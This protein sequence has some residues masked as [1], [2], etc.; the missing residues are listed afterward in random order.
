MDGDRVSRTPLQR[1]AE[2]VSH[3]MIQA[4]YG[5]PDTGPGDYRRMARAMDVAAASLGPEAKPMDHTAI[6]RLVRAERM[7]EPGAL[8]TLAHVLDVPY[9]D[10]LVQA[11][12]IDAQMVVESGTT[13]VASPLTPDAVAERWN[14]RDEAGRARVRA[15]YDELVERPAIERPEETP[16][17]A[18]AQ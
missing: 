9:T 6:G 12:I 10:L 2:Y 11:G 3:Q 13:Y 8:R 17:S 7:P 15:L 1:L 16:G 4:G 5:S 14:V 18:E